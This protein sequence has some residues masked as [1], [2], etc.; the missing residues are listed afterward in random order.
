MTRRAHAGWL[1]AGLAVAVV[2]PPVRGHAQGAE[3][4]IA[5]PERPVEPEKNPPGDIPDTQAFL[6][7][8]SPLGFSVKVPEGWARTDLP[9]GVR[10]ADKYDTVEVTVRD[11]ARAPTAAG[12]AKDVV[13]ALERSGR[14]V[15]VSAVEDV[16]LPAG[17]AVRIVYASNSDPNPVTD[18]R[19]RLE[20]EDYLFHKDGKLAT[21]HLAAPYGADN[22][23]DWRMMAHD[24]AWR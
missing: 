9:D 19:I 23:D 14:A 6:R 18:K 15:R 5:A 10:F 11:A 4:P 17:R 3:K 12:A 2:A 16:S 13:P 24:F 20:D 8:D 22:V 7:Y 21:L 1:L